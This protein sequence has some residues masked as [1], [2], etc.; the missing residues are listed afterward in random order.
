M[1]NGGLSPEAAL[2][3]AIA[4]SLVGGCGRGQIS[5]LVE[6][7]KKPIEDLRGL[8]RRDAAKALAP[9]ASPAPDGEKTF[10]VLA[11]APAKEETDHSL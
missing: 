9:A 8:Q 5:S 1:A 4:R 6:E 11:S 10:R 3:E 2:R 7:G